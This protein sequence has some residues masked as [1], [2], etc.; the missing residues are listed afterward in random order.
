MVGVRYGSTLVL[1]SLEARYLGLD[2]QQQRDLD[3]VDERQPELE[4]D[5]RPGRS[6][7]RHHVH[8]GQ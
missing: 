5:F 6:W 4:R 3:T 8:G 7:G 1:F 2:I